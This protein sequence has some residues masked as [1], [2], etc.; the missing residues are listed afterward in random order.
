MLWMYRTGASNDSLLAIDRWQASE[1]FSFGLIITVRE[2]RSSGGGFWWKAKFSGFVSLFFFVC[3][4]V[5]VKK[6]DE[7]RQ[8]KNQLASRRLIRGQWM[9]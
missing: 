3:L 7:I 1:G 5:R 8:K 9:M 2:R 6:K 4:C